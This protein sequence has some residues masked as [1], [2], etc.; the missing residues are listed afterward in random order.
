MTKLDLS[1]KGVK[2]GPVNTAFTPAPPVVFS[3]E[4]VIPV[5]APAPVAA[6]VAPAPVVEVAPVVT[7][8]P[9]VK[10]VTPVVVEETLS[11]IK[12]DEVITPE[13]PVTE[14]LSPADLV[15]QAIS[16]LE[17]RDATIA[18]QAARIAEL[19]GNNKKLQDSDQARLKKLE[20]LILTGRG[21]V[22][23]TA[24]STISNSSAGNTSAAQYTPPVS[25]GELNLLMK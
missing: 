14:T 17:A 19:E 10:E 5:A 20:S 15:E 3:S 11:D 1:M 18:Q 6:P 7:P 8:E 24:S 16:E 22:S 2:N 21:V 9:V 12:P 4:P 23:D 25:I 13:T